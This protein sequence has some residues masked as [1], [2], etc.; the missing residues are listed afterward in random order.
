[1]STGILCVLSFI[2]GEVAAFIIV[3]LLSANKGGK[4]GDKRQKK[5]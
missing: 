4:N 2:A 3:G 1:M 5:R